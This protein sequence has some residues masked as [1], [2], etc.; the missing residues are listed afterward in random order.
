L[1]RELDGSRGV[2]QPAPATSGSPNGNAVCCKI[3]LTR[4][5]VRL[6]F[7]CSISATTPATLGAAAE[8]PKKGS[9]FGTVVL[10]LSMPETATGL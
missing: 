8:V 3:C 9:K 6:G 7:A 2:D 5:K 1:H 4:A 10:M